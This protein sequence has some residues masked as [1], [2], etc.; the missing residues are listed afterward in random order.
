MTMMQRAKFA[1]I[2]FLREL[3]ITAHNKTVPHRNN[4]LKNG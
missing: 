3:G 1:Q 4:V 2:R